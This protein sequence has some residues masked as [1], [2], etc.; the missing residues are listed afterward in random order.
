V[1]ATLDFMARIVAETGQRKVKVTFHGGEPLVAGHT[2]WRQA[3]EGLA[4]RFGPGGYK[5][6][7]QSNLWLLDDEFS[8]MFRQHKV[9]IG[10]SLD[11][12][13]HLTNQQRGPGYFARTMSG[14]RKAQNHGM[15]VGCIATFTP[16]TLPHWRE[17]FDFFLN[18][19]LGFSIHAAV[20]P[21]NGSRRGNEAEMFL[22]PQQYGVLLRQMLD[23]C[24]AHRRELAVSSLDQMCQG[25]GCGEGKVCTFRNCFGMFLAIDPNGDIYPCQR[26]AGRP[27]YRLGTLA[28][29]PTLD[30]LFT[31]P[32]DQRLATRQQ[33]VSETCR[34]CSHLEYCQG[35]CPYNAWAAA[36]VS[37]HSSLIIPQLIPTA[38][39][40]GKSSIT[41]SNAS[42]L[43][44][45]PRR[46]STPSPSAPTPAP[47]THCSAKGR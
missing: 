30:R 19:R 5:V 16:L 31:S 21:L 10:T 47:V 1:E 43:R 9:E 4:A 33:T 42:L 2:L 24:I 6:A 45:R 15:T 40:T 44:W 17:V 22:T 12:P 23:Y 38:P 35:G 20:P 37:H 28:E 3:L 18:E 11:G 46:T 36:S 27:H 29:Q 8:E 7:L 13:E 41:S 25:L 26:F 34:D 14:I 32:V 39:P